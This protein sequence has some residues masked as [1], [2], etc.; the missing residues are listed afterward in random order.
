MSD[1]RQELLTA[2]RDLVATMHSRLLGAYGSGN[3][4]YEGDYE[5]EIQKLADVLMDLKREKNE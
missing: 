5:S 1:K 3:A 4:G 2:L